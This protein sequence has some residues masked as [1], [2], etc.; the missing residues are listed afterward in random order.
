ML[1]V[2]VSNIHGI[3]TFKSP[4][5][6]FQKPTIYFVEHNTDNFLYAF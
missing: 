1:I 6:I 4:D 2:A 5:A 3:K